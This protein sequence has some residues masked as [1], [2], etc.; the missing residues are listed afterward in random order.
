MEF[1]S[2]V[3]YRSVKVP[4][5]FRV[6]HVAPNS[7]RD[8]S[9][10]VDLSMKSPSALKE[11]VANYRCRS[12]EAG[13]VIK[14]YTTAQAESLAK[15]V[16][17]LANATGTAGT[18]AAHCGIQFQVLANYLNFLWAENEVMNSSRRLTCGGN[19]TYSGCSDLRTYCQGEELNAIYNHCLTANGGKSLLLRVNDLDAIAMLCGNQPAYQLRDVPAGDQQTLQCQVGGRKFGSACRAHARADCPRHIHESPPTPEGRGASV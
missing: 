1:R 9:Y 5:S 11:V 12:R 3:I 17:D 14:P 8:L 2:R 19:N 10:N 13:G 18:V 15:S 16:Y 7:G 4:S 6:E